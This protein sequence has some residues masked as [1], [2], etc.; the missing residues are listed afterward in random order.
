MVDLLVN[1]KKLKLKLRA[2][3]TQSVNQVLP[4][5]LKYVCGSDPPP[6][7]HNFTEKMIL[8]LGLILSI[9]SCLGP[10]LTINPK[11]KELS[12]RDLPNIDNIISP[13]AGWFSS[14]LMSWLAR[15][16]PAILWTIREGLV[17]VLVVVLVVLVMMETI[18]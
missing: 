10:A 14:L 4:S 11:Y 15:W 6:L 16:S 8:K 3:V 9:M 13:L 1:H 12:I 2:L 7:G 18:G 5:D 17:V